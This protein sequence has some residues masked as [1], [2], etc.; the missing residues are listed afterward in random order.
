[1]AVPEKVDVHDDGSD[2]VE[3]ADEEGQPHDRVV[4][5]TQVIGQPVFD[6]PEITSV[7]R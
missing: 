3:V 6:E 5:L 2:E 7:R 4:G 1:V